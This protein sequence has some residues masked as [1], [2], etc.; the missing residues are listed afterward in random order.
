MPARG[1]VAKVFSL[2]LEWLDRYCGL[3]LTLGY[4]WTVTVVDF[5]G[6]HYPKSVILFAVFFYLSYPVSYRD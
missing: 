2:L 3:G 1:F 6:A 4:D 5:K